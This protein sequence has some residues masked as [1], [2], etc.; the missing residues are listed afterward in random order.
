MTGAEGTLKPASL[1]RPRQIAW[2][3]T[4]A[5]ALL[6]LAIGVMTAGFS[7]LPFFQSHTF[8][9]L[10]LEPPLPAADFTL[11]NQDGQPVRLTDYEGKLVLLVFGYTQCPDACPLTLFALNQALAE[12]GDARG[13]VQVLMISVDP[14]T[15]TP[16]ALKEYLSHFNPGFVGLTGS[17]QEIEAVTRAYGVFVEVEKEEATVDSHANHLVAHTAPTYA[18]TALTYVVDRQG[19]RVL[20]L[21]L[22]MTPQDVAA[23]LNF[24]LGQ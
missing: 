21:P 15:D 24:L 16:K 8:H 20:A 7:R 1:S 22:E 14:Q 3:A 23:D 6:T 17:P 11:T 10:P 9:G 19:Q 5:A 13:Q 2:A 18:H 12:L 4:I